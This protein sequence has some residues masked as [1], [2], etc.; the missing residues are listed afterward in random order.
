MKS[1]QDYITELNQNGFALIPDLISDVECDKYKE[2]L[3]SDYK[4]YSKFYNCKATVSKGELADKSGEKVVYNLHNKHISW[5]KLFEE[6]EVVSILDM[7]LKD[8][9]YKNKEPYYLYNISARCPRKGFPGQQLHLDS[10][11]PGVNYPLVVNV[12]WLLDDFTMENGATR[13]IPGSHK[14]MSYPVDK[15]VFEE[16]I[17]IT[18]KKGSAI[19][20]NA[21]LYHGGMENTTDKT[22]WA[23]VLGYARWFIKPTFDF[24]QNTPSSIF[25]QLNNKQKELLGFNL[26]PSKDEFTR[27]RRISNDFDKPLEYNKLDQILK[28]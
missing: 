7:V 22:R 24:M 23:V 2:L 11:L 9:S 19:I 28:D 14:L 18:G 13:V 27:L 12:L 17:Y 25:N 21:N 10:R 26:T 16:E 5:F 6:E 4:K 15:K 1:T 20:F 3:E 8:G